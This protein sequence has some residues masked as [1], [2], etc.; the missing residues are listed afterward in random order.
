METSNNRRYLE[1][2]TELRLDLWRMSSFR[3]KNVVKASARKNK[4]ELYER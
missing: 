1:D 3:G 2:R 4:R